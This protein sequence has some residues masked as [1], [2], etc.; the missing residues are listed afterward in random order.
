MNVVTNTNTVLPGV[1]A[2]SFQDTSGLMPLFNRDP[3]RWTYLI[4]N[5]AVIGSMSAPLIQLPKPDTAT[6]QEWLEKL[7][8]S[9]NV[10]TIVVDNGKFSALFKQQLEFLCRRFDVVIVDIQHRPREVARLRPA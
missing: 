7:I 8:C 3:R 10:H 9:G 5:H 2:L 1:S 4:S 6:L